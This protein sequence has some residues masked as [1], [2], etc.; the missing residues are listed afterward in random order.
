MTSTPNPGEMLMLAFK[1]LDGP[2]DEFVRSLQEL[3]P[4]GVTLFRSFNIRNP[5][6][7]KSLTTS[8]QQKAAELDLPPLLIALDQEGGQLMAI[9]AATQLP[10]NMA[11]GA[12]GSEELA[13]EAGQ[14]LGSELRA[15]G[16]NVDY[17][18]CV[19]VNT[20]PNNPVV[21]VRSF[22]E[23]PT[24]VAR[25]SA[26]LVR[27]IQSKGVAA[28]A[29]HFPGHG[30]TSSDSHLGLP[31]VSHSL[32]EMR[33]IDLPPFKAAIEAGVKLVMTAHLGIPA[34]EQEQV[35]PA[36]LTPQILQ[37]IL[38]AE[39]GY[40]GVIITDAMD[41]LAIRQ[42]DLLVEDSA[43]AIA[44][45]VDLLLGTSDPQDHR[46][47]YKGIMHAIGEH[48][49]SDA[50][51]AASLNRIHLLKE[52]L[53]Q[54]RNIPSLDI[55]DGPAHREV[56]RRI[57]ERSIT[58]VRDDTRLLPLRLE[59]E[60]RIAVIVPKPMD[61]TPADTSSYSSPQLAAAV[62]MYHANTVEFVMPSLP[63]PGDIDGLLGQMSGIDLIIAGTLNASAQ[64]GQ[65]EL[66]KQLIALGKPVI[67]AAMRLPYDLAA[68]PKVGTYLCTYSIL[69]PSMQ[70]LAKV[71]FGEIKPQGRLPVSIPGMYDAGAG[72]FPT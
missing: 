52:W 13:F 62:R 34:L 40:D 16:V 72:I 55:V 68:F 25:L 31:L 59:A 60:K 15:M 54:D 56:A 57:A 45:G 64:P 12:T 51:L 4:A 3:K 8:L 28:T 19:D 43:N 37:G 58:L 70:A 32:E 69:E 48:M 33:S 29:K 47:L 67:A 23:D 49:I 71:L 61:L 21:G 44:A 5:R 42:G 53:T 46:R 7:L 38:R 30:D 50:Q 20:N 6:Q 2:S 1:G 17:A 41:M 36:T 22:G 35:T 63:S 9:G 65:A 26:A 14:V 39:L 66:V 11:L 18:P 10:G 27:G 24:S